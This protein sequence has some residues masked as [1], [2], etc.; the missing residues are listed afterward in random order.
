MTLKLGPETVL[1]LTNIKHPFYGKVQLK[2]YVRLRLDI[3]SNLKEKK[4]TLFDKKIPIVE[5]TEIKEIK[6]GVNTVE[7][8]LPWNF[9]T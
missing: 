5:A 4:F 9:K 6:H 8:T 3:E 2:L 1:V 7:I